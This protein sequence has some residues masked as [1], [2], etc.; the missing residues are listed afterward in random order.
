MAGGFEA[1][2]LLDHR[3]SPRGAELRDTFA[4]NR[5]PVGFHDVDDERG[6][7]A[8]AEL[9]LDDP[10]LPVVV[11]RFTPEPRIL[12]DPT[13]LAIA[14]AF[15]LA[16][17]VDQTTVRDVVLIGAG[18]AGLAAAVHAASEGLRTCVVEKAAVGGQAGTSSLIRNYP[19]FPRGLSGSKL[20]GSSFEQSWAF[21]AEY[22]FMREAV[23]LETGGVHAVRLSDG[24]RV[25]TRSVVVATGVAY[26]RLDVPGLEE[27][28]GRG[29]YYGAATTEAPGFQGRR[30]AVVG[31]GNSAGQAAM[32]LSRYA[33]EVAV[34]VRGTDLAASMSDY[35]VREI[36]ASPN[37]SVRHG[38]QVVG[39][40]GDL[41]LERV[42]LRD[43]RTGAEETVPMDG[44]F[45]LIGSEPHTEWLAGVVERD[46]WGFLV[47]GADLRPRPGTRMP[48]PLETSVPGVFAVG[49]VR[50]GSVK[51]VAS[52]VGEG[53]VAV[54]SVHQWLNEIRART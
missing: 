14:E 26:R 32:H 41:S 16:A 48:L 40:G 12:L 5:I 15:G 6:R 9:G 7:R 2:R 1:V 45:V 11:L 27:L 36:A 42:V 50:H 18:P 4:R 47:T 29:V 49:D 24:S 54:S 28:R 51:R 19:G 31:G 33:A 25:P 3:W 38:V 44:L 52:A 34:L 21:G 39:G 35:L 22:V 53:A 8:L 23:G 17:P 43:L 30:V 13:D 20:A 46:R 10:P 37:V